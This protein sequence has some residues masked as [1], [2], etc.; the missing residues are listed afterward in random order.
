MVLPPID[1]S[2]RTSGSLLVVGK[3]P[4]ED[5]IPDVLQASVSKT[6][7]TRNGPLGLLAEKFLAPGPSATSVTLRK[8]PFCKR[9]WKRQFQEL[10][11]GDLR[12]S[13]WKF[14]KDE[15]RKRRR[16]SKHQHLSVWEFQDGNGV[17]LLPG[18][19]PRDYIAALAGRFAD[20]SGNER[21][22]MND[23]SKFA[24]LPRIADAPSP[25]SRP[26]TN[27]LRQENCNAISEDSTPSP[28]YLEAALRQGMVAPVSSPALQQGLVAPV[29][30]PAFAIDIRGKNKT[31]Q[32]LV[33]STGNVS[34]S[35]GHLL[36]DP[37]QAAE[38]F[39]K[40]KLPPI[41]ELIKSSRSVSPSRPPSQ[42]K[43]S[44]PTPVFDF[45]SHVQFAP[46]IHSGY[47]YLQISQT[48]SPTSRA[49]FMP[50]LPS[51]SGR[52]LKAVKAT[53]HD[54]NKLNYNQEQSPMVSMKLLVFVCC[55]SNL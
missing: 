6:L 50:L 46:T 31:L 1:S 15:A 34:P 13:I 27:Y 49:E 38:R 53:P 2:R 22:R 47:S 23:V 12:Q 4:F 52:S 19:A 25:A 51:V 29:C 36:F 16:Q 43:H 44:C 37:W 10:K 55:L 32:P 24:V 40:R 11:M 48:T 33:R 42:R 8:R 9:K 35:S 39:D 17:G 5:H 7:S 26:G 45:N 30:S 20:K 41:T 14:D 28:S 3:R 21:H 54:S 18:F